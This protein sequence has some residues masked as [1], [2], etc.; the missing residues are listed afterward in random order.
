MDIK[1]NTTHIKASAAGVALCD[2]MG[3]EACEHDLELAFEK[4]AIGEILIA[5]ATGFAKPMPLQRALTFRPA[6]FG[7]PFFSLGTT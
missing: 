7:G 5:A 3:S 1:G 6:A 4:R 2:C